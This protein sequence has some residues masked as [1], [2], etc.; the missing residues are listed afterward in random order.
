M[1]TAA[2]DITART[3]AGRK[4][5]MNCFATMNGPAPRACRKDVLT[6][7]STNPNRRIDK[8]LPWRWQTAKP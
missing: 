8:L 7:P 1:S 2:P 5:F 3:P 6:R 4:S